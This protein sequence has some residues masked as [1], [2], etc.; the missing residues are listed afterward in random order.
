MPVLS[1]HDDPNKRT[2]SPITTTS[3]VVAI[4]YSGGVLIAAD[5]M[6]SYGKWKR[7]KDVDR[8]CN[9]NDNTVVCM[10]GEHSDFQEV[11]SMLKALETKDFLRSDG[12]KTQPQEIAHYLNRVYYNRRSKVNPLWNSVV[13]AGFGAE[14][15]LGYTDMYGTFF[16]EDQVA[17]GFA[18]YFAMPH[19]RREWRPDFTEAEAK[20]LALEC[21][22]IV[23]AREC[24]ASNKIRVA[25]V[26]AAGIEVS[27]EI[28][29]HPEWGHTHWSEKTIEL[30]L[31]ASTW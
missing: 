11:S 12:Y 6:V 31:A 14:P 19:L 7:F 15:Y 27:D 9:V 25:T 17:T 8:F 30:D 13:I 26:T 28:E 21:L 24:S 16:E 22:K 1:V 4:K 10:S 29:V 18:A 20:H 3:S 5:T 23:F 2:L